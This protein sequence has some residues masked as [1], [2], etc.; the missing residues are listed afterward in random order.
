MFKN[1]LVILGIELWQVKAGTL[2]DNIIVTD[3]IEEA[4]SFLDQTYN[5]Y[6]AA[7][8]TM[9][10][11]KDKKNV[12]KKKK[13]VNVLK[14]NVRNRMKKWKKMMMMT[15]MM[16]MTLKIKMNCN[17]FGSVMSTSYYHYYY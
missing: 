16:K 11:E 6:S 2:F 1:Q 13:N 17:Q 14:K 15:T 5:K 3:S 12:K 4:E 9:F 8:K 7:E 10:E